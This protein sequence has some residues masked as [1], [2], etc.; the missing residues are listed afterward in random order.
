M[1]AFVCGISSVRHMSLFHL[2]VLSIVILAPCLEFSSA[3]FLYE[4]ERLTYL[5][6]GPLPWM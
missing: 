5:V 3:G 2:A 1:A 4:G 6:T